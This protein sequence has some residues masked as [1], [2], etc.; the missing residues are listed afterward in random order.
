MSSKS[1]ECNEFMLNI[2]VKGARVKRQSRSTDTAGP[3]IAIVGSIAG[4]EPSAYCNLQI[5]FY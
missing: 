2:E 1:V 3:A 4:K 5:V